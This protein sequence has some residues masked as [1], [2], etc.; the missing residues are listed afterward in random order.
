MKKI[1][2]IFCT[3][4][5]LLFDTKGQNPPYQAG[6]KIQYLIHYGVINAGISTLELKKDTFAG[7]QVLHY[8]FLAQTTG[9]ADALYK[10]RD[11]YE[12]YIEPE[13]QLPVKSIRNIQEGNT[14]DIMLCFLIIR[15]D[16][17]PP[18]STATL[19][20]NISLKREFMISF[21]VS[22]ISGKKFCQRTLC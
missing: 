20:E 5:I 4:L 6:E 22:Y 17:I 12:S 2:L 13:S 10:I 14:E 18:F 1:L 19:Q 9:L 21:P 11:I 8:T 16:P 7:K 15:P 3:V